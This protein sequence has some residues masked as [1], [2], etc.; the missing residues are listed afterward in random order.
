MA[1]RRD[2][3]RDSFVALGEAL[4]GVLR[5]E[6]AVIAEAWKGSLRHLGIALGMFAVAGYI[7]LVC[8]PALLIFALVLGLQRLLAWTFAHWGM[9][10]PLWASALVVAALVALVVYLIV[11]MAV[12]RLRDRFESPVATVQ[13]RVAD[14]TAWWNERVLNGHES[15]EG[16]TRPESDNGGAPDGEGGARQG[17][18]GEDDAGDGAT[19]ETSPGA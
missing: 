16:A 13:E 19:G 12:K 17:H 3:W 18:P 8:L 15:A 10:W 5:A 4:I 1:N 9:A 2:T 6:L 7:A 14:H 11:R